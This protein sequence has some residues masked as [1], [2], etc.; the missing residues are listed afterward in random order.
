M[1]RGIRQGEPMKP[2]TKAYT[3]A[4]LRHHV[5]ASVGMKRVTEVTAHRVERMVRDIA[6]GK[7]AKDVKPEAVAASSSEEAMGLLAR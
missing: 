7:T 4:R 6:V 2:K 3:V 5:V 1:L